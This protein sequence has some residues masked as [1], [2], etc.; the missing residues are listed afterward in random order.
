M[1]LRAVKF[2]PIPNS[3]SNNLNFGP[4]FKTVER[5][6]VKNIVKMQ[7]TIFM[8]VL[9][10]L[11]ASCWS[12]DPNNSYSTSS[13]YSSTTQ[14]P[15]ATELAGETIWLFAHDEQPPE[16]V[17]IT[18]SEFNPATLKTDTHTA[19]GIFIGWTQ[20]R[21]YLRNGWLIGGGAFWSAK[22]KEWSRYEANKTDI[23][24]PYYSVFELVADFTKLG[25]LKN[26]EVQRVASLTLVTIWDT[27]RTQTGG[28]W[29]E[30]RDYVCYMGATYIVNAATQR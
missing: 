9:V 27:N 10:S 24:T 11:L 18:W 13:S 20:K 23:P 6:G 26:A 17:E 3:E 16:I 21:Q 2:L 1:N 12:L 8:L 22:T 15:S 25:I 30:D 14:K 29:I 5:I 28:M 7:K 4:S 19:N